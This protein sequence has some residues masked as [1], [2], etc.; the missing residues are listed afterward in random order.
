MK[1][2]G[3]EFWLDWIGD[4]NFRFSPSNDGII[5]WWF[6][7]VP[8]RYLLSDVSGQLVF[9]FL[10]WFQVQVGMSEVVGAVVSRL[11][12]AFLS[13]S[14]WCP[15]LL[16]LTISVSFGLGSSCCLADSRLC[17]AFFYGF[18][19]WPYQSLLFSFNFCILLQ[20]FYVISSTIENLVQNLT[21]C[22]N[23]EEQFIPKILSMIITNFYNII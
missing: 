23:E 6:S 15:A 22:Q 4:G 5:A 13:G 21:F 8:R 10:I 12:G 20:V 19:S 7:L 17:S 11:E 18:C 14:S 1:P 16:S 9:G 2:K 3:E